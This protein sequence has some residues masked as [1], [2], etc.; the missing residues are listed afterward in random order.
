MIASAELLD[1]WTLDEMAACDE[2]MPL[3]KDF[4]RTHTEE[5]KIVHGKGARR[6]EAPGHRRLQE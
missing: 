5:W 1:R 4:A 3:L 6:S 2:G